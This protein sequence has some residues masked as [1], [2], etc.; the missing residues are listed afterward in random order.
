VLV[1]NEGVTLRVAGPYGEVEEFEFGVRETAGFELTDRHGQPRPDGVYTWELRARPVL[2]AGVRRELEQARETGDETVAP[3]LR[4][5]GL[6]P[7]QPAV[8]SGAFSIL[9]GLF[10]ASGMPEG[11]Q[12]GGLSAVA[13]PTDDLTA[14]AA[15]QVIADDLIV[16]QSLCVGFDCING[17]DFG[18]DTIRLKENN[19]QIAFVDTSVGTFPTNDWRIQA[20]DTASGSAS[21]LTIW[22]S[23]GGRRPLTIEAGARSNALYVNSSGR[24]GF[25]TSVPVYEQHVLD[26]DTPGVRLDQDGSFGFTPQVWDVAGNEANFFIRDVTGGS[27]LPFRIQPGAPTDTLTLRAGG[28]VGIGTWSPAERVHVGSVASTDTRVRVDGPGGTHVETVFY[29]GA[30]RSGRLIAAL[31]NPSGARYF[32]FLSYSDKDGARLPVRF[33]TTDAG[34]TLRDTLYLGAGQAAGQ[35]GWVGIGTVSP[36]HPLEMASGAHV[37]AGGVWTDASSRSFKQDIAELSLDDAEQTLSALEPVTFAYRADPTE[38]YVGFIAEDVPAL[39]ATGDRTGL[40]PMD[41]VAVLTKVVQD[42]QKTI[43]EL[44]ARVA[45]LETK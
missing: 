43:A 4:R 33:F 2:S 45:Q 13:V 1:P 32:G 3:R 7:R 18:F 9:G 20:N 27:R 41:I 30:T 23:D 15:D 16:Q 10:V 28:K 40:S 17:E 8:S 5:Q 42:Q 19:T 37:T 38:K 35:P 44:Q 36:G 12:D 6:L 14:R 21:Y 31:G 26:G 29:D 25:G 22:D 11:D 39:V 24:V 34:G